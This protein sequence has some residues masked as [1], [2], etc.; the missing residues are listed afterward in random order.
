MNVIDS[1]LGEFLGDQRSSPR[2]LGMPS[3]NKTDAGSWVCVD[4]VLID[5]LTDRNSDGQIDRNSDR[6]IGKKIG[7]Q[8]DRQIE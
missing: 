3:I 2:H 4:R 1:K 7:R 5:R 6:W 8:S